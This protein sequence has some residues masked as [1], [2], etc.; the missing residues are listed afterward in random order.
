MPQ[1]PSYI[2]QLISDNRFL[3]TGFFVSNTGII[4][5][6][7]HVLSPLGEQPAGKFIKF[8]LLNST[9]ELD[10]VITDKLDAVNDVALLKLVGSLPSQEI[11]VPMLLDSQL[12]KGNM[13]LQVTG[14]G[15]VND[16]EHKYDFVSAIGTIAGSIGRDGLDLIQL[17]SKQILP[18]MSGAPVIIEEL[19]GVIGIVSGRYSIDPNSELWLRDMAWAVRI[20]HL[21][22]LESEIQIADKPDPRAAIELQYENRVI[23]LLRIMGYT[24]TLGASVKDIAVPILA[25]LRLA[26]SS[27][28]DVIGCRESHIDALM[29]A[30]G[31]GLPDVTYIAL[32]P[33]HVPERLKTTPRIQIRYYDNLASSFIDFTSYLNRVIYDYEHWN[34]F[35]DERGVRIRNPIIDIMSNCDLYKH[36][37]EQD[38]LSIESDQT[39]PMPVLKY[40]ED[41]LDSPNRNHLSV[42]GD[43]GTGKSSLCLQLTYLLAQKY[44]KNPGESRI[45]LFISLRDYTKAA[46]IRQMITDLL[47]NQYGIRFEGFAAFQKFLEGGRLVLLFDGFD[48]MATKTDRKVT[49]KNWE[50]LTRVVTI[51]SKT[52]LTCR[53]HYFTDQEHVVQTLRSGEGSHL[54]HT[55]KNRP[56]FEIILLQEFNT[57]QVRLLLQ[58]YYPNTWRDYW[59]QIQNTLQFGDIAHRPILLDM[60]IKTIPQGIVTS[61]L[62]SRGLNVSHLYDVYTEAWILRDDWRSDMTNEGKRAFM[63]DLAFQMWSEK[64]NAIH[65]RDLKKPIQAYFKEKLDTT[66]DLDYYV[67]DVATSTFLSRDTNGNYRFM[68]KSFMEYFAAKKCISEL[69]K[70]ETLPSWEKRWFDKEVA[71]FVSQS[72]TKDHIARL[73]KEIQT[74]DHQISGWNKRHVLSYVDAKDLTLAFPNLAET[75]EKVAAAQ[76]DAVILRQDCRIINSLGGNAEPLMHNVIALMQQNV[77]QKTANLDTYLVFYGSDHSAADAMLNH[78]RRDTFTYDSLLHI[79]VIGEFGGVGHAIELERLTRIQEKWK[80]KPQY[81]KQARRAIEQI[82][83]RADAITPIPPVSQPVALPPTMT[84]ENEH[85]PKIAVNSASIT[86]LVHVPGIGKALAQR[87]IA[88]RRLHGEFKSIEEMLNVE[89]IGN[90]K[91][92][93]LTAYLSVEAAVLP[94]NPNTA[95]LEELTRIP[96]IGKKLAH[97]I[98]EY[99]SNVGKFAQLSDLQKVEGM[100][101]ARLL[102][103]SSYLKF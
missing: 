2:G 96:G 70:S 36:Y 69:E 33:A 44:V 16:D 50:E 92:R 25:E 37:V 101:K 76:Q 65:Y 23:D 56:N 79:Y 87:I 99:R 52:I 94:V 81:L 46:D 68:H 71:A 28:Q 41:W 90:A 83:L 47:L 82:R 43:F 38:C 1:V 78:L 100:G 98:I 77:D 31:N 42:L 19:G 53:T 93:N 64:T 7:Y 8:H 57:K 26:L 17:D 27:K 22:S 85:Q 54:L 102:R 66:K 3:G 86:E 75:L 12:A 84:G 73:I 49:L 97:N 59:D 5:T 24:V 58:S 35:V 74:D 51:N 45:P 6:C 34:E 89:G 88:Y 67:N 40:I 10:C 29:S 91:L 30:V 39:Q 72:L 13:S 61:A 32:S 4:A 60:I 18:G 14:Y 9:L 63:E 15:Q 48:E 55:I 21:V 62:S 11:R 80:Q 20:E 95:N 103:F